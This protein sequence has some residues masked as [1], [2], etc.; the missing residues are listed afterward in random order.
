M[1]TRE[2]IYRISYK[3]NILNNIFSFFPFFFLQAKQYFFFSPTHERVYWYFEADMDRR[4]E[5]DHR[6]RIIVFWVDV[7]VNGRGREKQN[8]GHQN[9]SSFGR[10]PGFV[11]RTVSTNRNFN[12]YCSFSPTKCYANSYANII[13]LFWF[14]R[15]NRR[16]SL[17]YLIEQSFLFQFG[18][19]DYVSQWILTFTILR[20][21]KLVSSF[22]EMIVYRFNER[23]TLIMWKGIFF[24]P[25]TCA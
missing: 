4:I 3:K 16:Y 24:Y 2:C 9:K 21:R 5:T 13:R 25:M 20:K 8:A 23:Y 17:S 22:V 6:M 15:Y 18:K 12:G 19:A 11:N 7:E 1:L 14:V 10:P